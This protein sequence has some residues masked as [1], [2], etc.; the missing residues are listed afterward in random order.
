[1]SASGVLRGLTL[2][3]VSDWAT[4]LGLIFG[5]CCRYNVTQVSSVLLV[6]AGVVLTT[7]SASASAP[8]RRERP[9][10][11]PIP[12]TEGGADAGAG[13]GWLSR[14]QWRYA[15]GIALLT[16]ALVLSGLLGIVQDWTYA[17]VVLFGDADAVGPGV[18]AGAGMVFVGTMGY[19]LGS[20]IGAK[21]KEKGKGKGK[22]E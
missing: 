12:A 21:E 9:H 2:G 17:R 19:A 6:T 8:K 1:M 13:G 5:G 15:T 22:R 4:T 14:E 3:V 16:L 18:W 10:A 11:S 7:L 20:R